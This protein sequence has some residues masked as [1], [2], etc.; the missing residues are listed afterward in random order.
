[1]DLSLI[2][3]Y[4]AIP[5]QL[6]L[7]SRGYVAGRKRLSGVLD[8]DHHFT[9][10]K[11]KHHPTVEKKSAGFCVSVV[12]EKPTDNQSCAESRSV[13]MAVFSVISIV[14]NKL[15]QPS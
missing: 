4:D 12:D 13:T 5:Y 1:M 9:P 10:V 15:E 14:Q 2:N 8:A 3:E 11:S 7:I 6:G